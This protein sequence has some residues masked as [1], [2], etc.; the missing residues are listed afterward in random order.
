MSQVQRFSAAALLAFTRDALS[1]CGV[2]AADAEIAAKQMIEADL[3]GFDAHG[4][5]RLNAY[6]TT[7]KSGRTNTKANIRPIHRSAAT[8]VV[9]GDN[10][11]G[12]LV[13]T[14]CANLAIELARQSG[15]GRLVTPRATT[16]SRAVCWWRTST[17]PTPATA[18]TRVPP[19]S[20]TR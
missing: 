6:V 9:D 11:I 4:V 8:A 7:L 16:P 2:P 14:Y 19:N 18:A 1:S 3:T 10:G 5:F 15:V 17:V 20:W 12:H 13:M